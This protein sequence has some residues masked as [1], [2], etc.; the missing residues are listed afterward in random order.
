MI[1]SLISPKTQYNIQHVL[2]N[3]KGKR[4]END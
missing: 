3:T 1:S 2:K 4:K